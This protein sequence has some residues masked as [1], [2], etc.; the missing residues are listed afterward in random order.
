LFD[1]FLTTLEARDV[2]LRNYLDD[3]NS[4]DLRIRA[5]SIIALGKTGDQNAARHLIGILENKNEVDWLRGCAA[6]ALSRIPGEEVI[7]PLIN[8]LRGDSLLVSRAAILALG[9]FANR[10]FSSTSLRKAG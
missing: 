7:Q 2:E 10:A 5:S 9:V 3:L 8:A 6:I 1:I 4:Q